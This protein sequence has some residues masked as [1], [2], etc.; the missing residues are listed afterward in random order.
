MYAVETKENQK[1]IRH[2]LVVSLTAILA[3]SL[4]S[5]FFYTRAD[6]GSLQISSDIEFAVPAYNTTV[7]ASNYL[8]CNSF[9]WSDNNATTVTFEEVYMA[10]GVPV[11]NLDVTVQDANL[12]FNTLG[13]TN[14]NFNLANY[15]AAPSSVDLTGFTREPAQITVDG[16][17]FTNYTYTSDTLS[18]STVGSVV[19]ISF[20]AVA[21]IG[22]VLG[23]LGFV[24]AVI[25]IAMVI[26]YRK[27]G[28]N[29]DE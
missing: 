7:G 13:L 4:L 2:K 22:I 29:Q 6:V 25:A 11:S 20:P 28:N 14:T 15:T 10:S 26:I 18:F 17:E 9:G 21:D 27:R 3:V 24:F 8:Y 5:S 23:V 12:T 16:A 1:Q 19:D